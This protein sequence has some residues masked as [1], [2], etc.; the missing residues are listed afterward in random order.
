MK[1]EQKA[2]AEANKEEAHTT[3]EPSNAVGATEA[4][5]AATGKDVTDQQKAQTNA[6]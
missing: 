5:T 1:E 3:E 6:V 2:E 4:A